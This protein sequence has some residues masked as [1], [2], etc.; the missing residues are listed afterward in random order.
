M[1]GAAQSSWLPASFQTGAD[2]SRGV[3]LASSLEAVVQRRCSKVVL[4]CRDLCQV[5]VAVYSQTERFVAV[6]IKL[7]GSIA[8]AV[9]ENKLRP[10]PAASN[11]PPALSS[12]LFRNRKEHL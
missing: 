11:S 7:P 1:L 9:G 4:T 8:P 3:R 5:V 12:I 2:L 10:A 6:T